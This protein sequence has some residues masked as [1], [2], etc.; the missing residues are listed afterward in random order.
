M[1]R[2]GYELRKRTVVAMSRRGWR[3][4]FDPERRGR[5]DMQLRVEGMDDCPTHDAEG[6]PIRRVS[7]MGFTTNREY[8][9]HLRARWDHPIPHISSAVRALEVADYEYAVE[10][11]GPM[12]ALVQ[13]V[14]QP[15]DESQETGSGLWFEAFCRT[16]RAKALVGLG[17]VAEARTELDAA[18]RRLRELAER[19]RGPFPPGSTEAYQREEVAEAWEW[20]GESAREAAVLEPVPT[21]EEQLA[22]HKRYR[23]GLREMDAAGFDIQPERMEPIGR[24]EIMWPD[25]HQIRWWAAKM[26]DGIQRGEIGDELRAIAADVLGSRRRRRMRAYGPVV[27]RALALAYEVLGDRRRARDR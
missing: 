4:M 7:E 26:E 25:Y 27:E 13:F 20:L 16:F 1:N 23:Q 17:R 19:E 10:D 8:D 9:A 6:N 14:G 15:D 21:R 24:D 12:D 3:D 5:L 18:E 22:Q 2:L 11:L